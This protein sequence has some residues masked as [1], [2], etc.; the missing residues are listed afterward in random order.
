[1][2]MNNLAKHG[3]NTTRTA[4]KASNTTPDDYLSKLYESIVDCE[5]IVD[6]LEREI[7]LFQINERMNKFIEI[8]SKSLQNTIISTR[9]QTKDS[10][11]KK[12]NYDDYDYFDIDEF[13]HDQ[14]NSLIEYRK[15]NLFPVVEKFTFLSGTDMYYWSG[16]IMRNSC[17]RNELRGGVRQCGN[18]ECGKW[19][20]YPREFLKCRRC[21]R[22]K[23]CSRDCQMRAWH[24][25]RNWCIPSTSSATSNTVSSNHTSA[26]GGS[27]GAGPGQGIGG[28]EVGHPPSQSAESNDEQENAQDIELS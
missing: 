28:N 9:K 14:D 8:E 22:T 3:S 12:W 24:S 1:M 7:S 5:S 17:R 2:M 25:H 16:V 19:E 21:R 6:D 23:Y 20:K 18:L 10:L 13:N 4:N 15:V 27:G 26:V 11:I